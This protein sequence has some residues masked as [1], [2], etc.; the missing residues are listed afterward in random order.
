MLFDLYI[1]LMTPFALLRERERLLS[2]APDDHARPRRCAGRRRPPSRRSAAHKLA[3]ALVWMAVASGA[4]VFSEPAPVDVLT[5]G[6]IV[7]L[8]V[9][10]LVAMSRAL[11]GLLA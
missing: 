11:L 3:L 10:G 2:P 6:L 9:I 5:M 8:P 4:V 7:L 1:L